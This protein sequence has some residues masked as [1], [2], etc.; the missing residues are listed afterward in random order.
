MA[1]LS[2]E[3]PNEDYRETRRLVDN[4][5]KRILAS[6]HSDDDSFMN[7]LFSERL[8]TSPNLSVL[9]LLVPPSCRA[10]IIYHIVLRIPF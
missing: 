2:M 7:A 6:Q 1:L 8:Q 4:G 9:K 10:L 5:S 3:N